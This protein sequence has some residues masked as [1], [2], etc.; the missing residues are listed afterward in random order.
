MLVTETVHV[1]KC[2]S[3]FQNG[4]FI[5]LRSISYSA[6]F[7]ES[8]C[9]SRKWILL[10]SAGSKSNH[11][12]LFP[13]RSKILQLEEELTYRLWPVSI[14][15][16]VKVCYTDS[17]DTLFEQS[18]LGALFKLTVPGIK[19]LNAPV[20]SFTKSC[21]FYFEYT[22]VYKADYYLQGILDS[23]G[24]TMTMMARNWRIYLGIWRNIEV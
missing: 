18:L 12:R 11:M 21:T 17:Q 5:I 22:P 13:S 24:S 23:P 14:S 3:R 8:L 10:R 16:P 2:A 20:R 15:T 19:V 6:L 9:E 4:P 7:L 1:T